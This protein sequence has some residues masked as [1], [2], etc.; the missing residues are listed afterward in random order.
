LLSDK[1]KEKGE[2]KDKAVEKLGWARNN[3]TRWMS[4]H[5]REDFDAF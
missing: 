4:S 2:L 5:L 3:Q 1:N